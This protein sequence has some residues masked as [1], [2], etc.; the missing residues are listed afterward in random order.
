MRH[1]TQS[2]PARYPMTP[3][4]ATMPLLRCC[5]I[6]L[7]C[8][9]FLPAVLAGYSIVQ[10]GALAYTMSAALRGFAPDSRL[11][12]SPHRLVGPPPTPR[13]VY[14]VL[15]VSAAL[16]PVSV[17]VARGACP[18][19]GHFFDQAHRARLFGASS[20][21]PSGESWSQRPPV[22]IGLRPQR[23]IHGTAVRER[24][25]TCTKI[26]L[27]LN[28]CPSCAQRYRPSLEIHVIF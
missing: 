23:S 12:P 27:T 10:G 5:A 15:A 21:G 17:V 3:L 8:P 4:I 7:F 24:P 6:S 18:S 28:A 25:Y 22:K 9:P 1:C 11:P 19:R 16:Q 20:T 14:H 26:T 13:K 2:I